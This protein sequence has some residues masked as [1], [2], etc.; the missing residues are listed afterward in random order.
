MEQPSPERLRAAAIG[1]RSGAEQVARAHR[2][3]SRHRRWPP[4]GRRLHQSDLAA[5]GG[6]SLKEVRRDFVGRQG[7]SDPAQPVLA[8]RNALRIYKSWN[9]DNPAAGEY[10][11]PV[12]VRSSIPTGADE[13]AASGAGD[14][15]LVWR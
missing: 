7:L 6:G 11:Y 9:E 5:L 2:P 3:A 15:F 13:P 4:T 10:H 14:P 8:R 1:S 12:P